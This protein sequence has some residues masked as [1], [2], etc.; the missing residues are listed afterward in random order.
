M[1]DDSQTQECVEIG[2][3]AYMTSVVPRSRSHL[4]GSLVYYFDVWFGDQV[5][6]ESILGMEFMVPAGMRLDLADGT[7]CLPDEFRISLAGR[8]PSGSQYHRSTCRLT[9]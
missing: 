3:N 6:Q 8:R 9:D 4:D 7:L 5:G 2:E 1:V